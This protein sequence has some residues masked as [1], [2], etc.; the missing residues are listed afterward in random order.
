MGI[1]VRWF[2]IDICIIVYTTTVRVH[3]RTCRRA[4]SSRATLFCAAVDPPIF[5]GEL[6]CCSPERAAALR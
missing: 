5:N 4:R 6:C 1:D 3:T 2:T